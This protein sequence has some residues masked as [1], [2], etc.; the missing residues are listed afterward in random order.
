MVFC[1][2][3]ILAFSTVSVL[4]GALYLAIAASAGVLLW[5]Y[6]NRRKP[7]D[8]PGPIGLPVIG[9][10]PFLGSNPVVSLA[11]LSKKYGDI[12]R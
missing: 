2:L 5:I 11:N 4:Y 8:M 7:T 3:G 10:L 9:Y 12:F 1:L 6:W